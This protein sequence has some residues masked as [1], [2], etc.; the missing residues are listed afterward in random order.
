MPL[1]HLYTHA[2]ILYAPL[3]PDLVK[4]PRRA[5]AARAARGTEFDHMDLIYVGIFLVFFALSIAMVWA[6]ERL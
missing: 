3:M 6:L 1:R 2:S 5:G 4:Y